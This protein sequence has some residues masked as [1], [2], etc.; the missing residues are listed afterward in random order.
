VPATANGIAATDL[1]VGNG[2]QSTDSMVT[3]HV[4]GEDNLVKLGRGDRRLAW[5]ALA[6]AA[7]LVLR[8][9]R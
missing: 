6:H 9:R 2:N 5:L 3:I 4:D 8:R 1:A 7:S